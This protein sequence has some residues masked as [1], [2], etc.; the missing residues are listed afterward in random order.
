M[1]VKI[2]ALPSV[3]GRRIV[4]F[5]AGSVVGSFFRGGFVGSGY[6][7]D[8]YEVLEVMSYLPPGP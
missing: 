3:D 1:I 5:V 7:G 6:N 2:G 4:Q 8:F